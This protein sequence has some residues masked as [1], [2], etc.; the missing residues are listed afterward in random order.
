MLRR[1][2]GARGKVIGDHDASGYVSVLTRVELASM[3]MG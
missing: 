1:L 3:L 2:S